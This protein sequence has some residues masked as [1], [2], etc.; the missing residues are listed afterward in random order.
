MHTDKLAINWQ[1][2]TRVRLQL[3]FAFI[4][5]LLQHRT[6]LFARF[7][8]G[9][10]STTGRLLRCKNTMTCNRIRSRTKVLQHFEMLY[11][12]YIRLHFFGRSSVALVYTVDAILWRR[13][14]LLF[15]R[16]GK[17][18]LLKSFFLY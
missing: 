15:P 3:K 5:L 2:F 10:T 12:I 8:S 13:T 18:S 7:L 17:F 11:E 14:P 16:L 6:V 4:I 9:W 1:N